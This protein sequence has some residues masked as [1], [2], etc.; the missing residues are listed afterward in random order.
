MK[1]NGNPRTE[2]VFTKPPKHSFLTIL[3]TFTKIEATPSVSNLLAFLHVGMG[4]S[5]YTINLLSWN[6]PWLKYLEEFLISQLK[7]TNRKLNFQIYFK[8]VNLGSKFSLLLY[9]SGLV[10]LCVSQEPL[11]S[12]TLV[13]SVILSGLSLPSVRNVLEVRYPI[14]LM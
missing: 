10:P 13:K 5:R 8:V 4:L 6:L 3:I 7:P 11:G 14:I 2:D 9:Y 1:E 12:A